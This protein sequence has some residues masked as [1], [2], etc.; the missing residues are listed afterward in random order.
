[1]QKIAI[2]ENI[3]YETITVNNAINDKNISQNENSNPA[4]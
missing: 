2:N 4:K 3:K 1:M